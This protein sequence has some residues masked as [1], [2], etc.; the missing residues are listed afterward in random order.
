MLAAALVFLTTIKHNNVI[1]VLFWKHSIDGG[2][3]YALRDEA[4]NIPN[5][6]DE[7]IKVAKMLYAGFYSSNLRR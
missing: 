4:G 2:R 7:A 5:N 3:M 6:A 1:F